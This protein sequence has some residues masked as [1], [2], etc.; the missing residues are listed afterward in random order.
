M[1]TPPHNHRQSLH[2]YDPARAEPPTEACAD[3]L[4]AALGDRE[5]RQW[6]DAEQSFDRAFRSKLAEVPVPADLPARILAAAAKEKK[7]VPL[8]AAKEPAEST[9]S[10]RNFWH[11]SAFSGAAAAVLFLAILFTFMAPPQLEAEAG[12][13]PELTQLMTRLED[14]LQNRSAAVIRKNDFPSLVRHLEQGGAPVPKFIPAGL[15]Q[16]QG[17]AC[18]NLLVDNIPVGMMCFKVDDGVYHIFTI[19][20]AHLPSQSDL[21][22]EI[23]AR[24][25]GHCCATWTRDD[26]LY[27]L[28]TQ[29][30]E[31]K[32]LTLL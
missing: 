1:E 30:P 23:I 12:P 19:D 5:L 7:T 18:A 4:E 25:G 32:L 14:V 16:K 29:E 24:I 17:F 3:A 26:Q 15:P 20:R 13:T 8:R 10:G 27:I 2:A 28:A 31:E 21:P 9:A 6:W 22:K 11:W